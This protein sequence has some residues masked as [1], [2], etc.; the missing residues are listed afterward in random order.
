MYKILD[1]PLTVH[2]ELNTKCNRACLHCY[3]YWRADINVDKL[4]SKSLSINIAKQLEKNQVFYAIVTGGEPMLNMESLIFLIQNLRQKKITFGLNSNLSLMTKINAKQLKNAGLR[5]ILTSLLSYNETTHNLLSG[6][7]Q[8][9]QNI[10]NGIKIALSTGLRVAINM[11]VTKTNIGHVEKTGKLAQIIG[12]FAFSA[13]RVIVPRSKSHCFNNNLA[14]NENDVKSLV[15]QM[16]KL[17]GRGLQLDSL[18]PYP[19][20]FFDNS[21]AWI[22]L[23]R[24]TCSAGK[25]SLVIAADG[26]ARACPHHENNYGSLQNEDLGSIWMKMQDWRDGLMLPPQ[27]R[28]CAMFPRCGGGCRM[29]S[30]DGNICGLDS[31][32]RQPADAKHFGGLEENDNSISTNTALRVKKTCR[33]RNDNALGVINIGGIKNVFVNHDTLSLLQELHASDATFSPAALKATHKIE[34]EKTEYINFLNA[35]VKKKV[36]E[37]VE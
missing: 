32:A 33:F 26:A 12:A 24:R 13:T 25:T 9:F 21:E 18:I 28:A 27:C 17:K 7:K 34:M 11:V 30:T 37:I 8:S 4:L 1:A 5:T 36:L 16:Q 31:I 19:S 15:N 22:L 2:I 35:L 6:S 29:A 3:N 20:C 23:A 14:L 10:M